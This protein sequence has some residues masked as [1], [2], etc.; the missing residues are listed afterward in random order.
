MNASE[1]PNSLPD[2][3]YKCENLGCDQQRVWRPHDLR[4][5]SGN[6]EHGSAAGFHCEGCYKE[7]AHNGAWPSATTLATEL[8]QHRGPGSE[9]DGT[10]NT[11]RLSVVGTLVCFPYGMTFVAALDAPLVGDDGESSIWQ[12]DVG[13][14]WADTE[15]L[16]DDL[17]R[18][19]G[20]VGANDECD[21][22][23]DAERVELLREGL[24]GAERQEL[25][26]C[27]D[28]EERWDRASQLA[29]ERFL[30]DYASRAS[31]EG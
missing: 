16:P 20:H 3:F 27:T 5:S 19:E 28:P 2:P 30:A 1:T 26:A 18:V 11:M 25:L 12:I 4:W 31:G 24:T 17:V 21:P 15:F 8:A 23:L 14:E 7:N 13:K 10:A 29:R 22:F 6:A 9:W